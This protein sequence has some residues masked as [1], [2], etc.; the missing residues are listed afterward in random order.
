VATGGHLG[1]VTDG[2]E[3]VKVQRL[4]FGGV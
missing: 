1:Q 3:G 2:A 4:G